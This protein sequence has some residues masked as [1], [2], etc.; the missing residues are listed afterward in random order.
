MSRSLFECFSKAGVVAVFVAVVHTGSVAAQD[1]PFNVAVP[2]DK[3]STAF[4]QLYGPGGLI[5]DSLAVLSDGS[6]HSAHFNSDFQASFAQFGTALTSQLAST[7]LPSP[8]SGFTFEF[9][10]ELGVFE[11]STQSFG[12]ILGDRA[13]TI[14]AGRFS[15]GF[16]LQRFSF[17]TIEGLDIDRVPA[18]FTHDSAEL[19]GGREDVVTTVNSIGTRVNQFTTFIT[20]GLNDR[21]DLSLAIPVVNTDLTIVSEATVQRIGTA[22][23]NIHF[24]REGD[25]SL[26]EQRSFTAFGSASGLGDLTLRVKGRAGQNL[27]VGMDI[28][29]PT[30]DEE[31]LLGVG[32]PGIKP[33]LVLSGSAGKFAPHLNFGYTWNG[34]SVLAGD[35]ASGTTS[36]LPDQANFIIGADFG[37]SERFTFAFDVLGLYLIDAPRLQ[38]TDFL[39]LDGRSRFAD[40]NFVNES[41]SQL[42]GAVGFKL[43]LVEGL[44]LDLNLLF[45]LDDNG[46]RDQ[47]TPLVGFEYAF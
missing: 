13:E 2:I 4:V 19:R 20:Y 12:P 36:D 34:S 43:Q 6:T 28:R 14:G 17:D 3:L 29:V 9:D 30:G 33:F 16:T 38:R 47:I 7:P 25:G 42:S 39:A 45:N 26:G 11:R 8:A 21:L 37:V 22:D 31:N 27:A 10:P 15:F 23:P 46:L 35:V 24:F 5:V 1:R 41:Y 44:L 32:A 40:I 18:V